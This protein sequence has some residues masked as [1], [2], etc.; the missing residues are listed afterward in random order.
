MSFKLGESQESH[1]EGLALFQFPSV[2]TT[3]N[4]REWIELRPT[5]QI[6]HGSPSEFNVSGKVQTIL[7]LKILALRSK[8]V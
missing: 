4:N 8:Y 1:G 6:S 2:V 5:A 3:I 7:T